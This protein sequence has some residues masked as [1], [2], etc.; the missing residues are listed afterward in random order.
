MKAVLKPFRQRVKYVVKIK[1]SDGQYE[2]IEA[3]MRN[4]DVLP[5]PYFKTEEMYTGMKSN[6]RYTLDD[7]GITYD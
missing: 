1:I 5:F 6:E 3:A 7:L 2:Y 4:G